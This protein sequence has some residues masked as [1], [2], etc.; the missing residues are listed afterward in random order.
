MIRIRPEHRER[1]NKGYSG[2]S[3]YR[4]IDELIRGN[5]KELKIIS[6]FIGPSYAKMLVDQAANKKI[7][8]ITAPPRD[9][10]FGS[11][12]SRSIEIMKSRKARIGIRPVA[13]FTLF[14]VIAFAF[15]L[16][17][18]TS[19]LSAVAIFLFIVFI[20]TKFFIPN[21]LRLKVVKGT[22]IHEKLY[23]GKNRAITGSA[24]LTGSG[25]HSNIEHV[26]IIDDNERISELKSHFDDLWSQ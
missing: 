3:S 6:P 17:L 1:R 24:N 26:E 18:I 19:V 14:A 22:F 13:A 21:N 9:D 20:Y 2:K 23:I 8:V 25:T 15:N 11:S 7:Y 16:Y 5:S 12:Q 4:Y 10:K